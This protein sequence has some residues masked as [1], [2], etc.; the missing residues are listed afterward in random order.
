M[1]SVKVI[2]NRVNILVLPEFRKVL[3]EWEELGKSGERLVGIIETRWDGNYNLEEVMTASR[4]SAPGLQDAKRDLL[5]TIAE[6]DK[7]AENE[8]ETA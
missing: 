3:K 7:V 5:A 6:Y 8:R 4:F 2:V 1:A